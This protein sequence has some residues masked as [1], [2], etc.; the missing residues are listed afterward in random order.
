MEVTAAVAAATT[1]AVTGAHCAVLTGTAGA[2]KAA[3]MTG[4]ARHQA[5]TLLLQSAGL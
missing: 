4:V 3:E 5:R 2:G 1:E